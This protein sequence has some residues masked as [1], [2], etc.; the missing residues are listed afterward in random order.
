MLSLV[1]LCLRELKNNFVTHSEI[2]M[3][4][5]QL[6]FPLNCRFFTLVW[7]PSKKLIENISIE[8]IACIIDNSPKSMIC[9]HISFN[10]LIKICEII[11]DKSLSTM[12]IGMDHY[13]FM[14]VCQMF[15]IIQN[16]LS[17]NFNYYLE[18]CCIWG[19]HRNFKFELYELL[20]QHERDKRINELH[21]NDRINYFSLMNI[22]DQTLLFMH[23]SKK[24][25][26][27]AVESIVS[28][29]CKSRDYTVAIHDHIYGTIKSTILQLPWVK[30]AHL[31]NKLYL[32]QVT[33]L[34]KS[35][36]IKRLKYIYMQ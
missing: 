13:K 32:D 24:Q 7:P 26:I 36:Q 34:C 19:A 23:L 16:K 33:D 18:K 31:F 30:L 29:I 25:K 8:T 10:K 27:I 11:S 17:R 1:E 15:H 35:I 20:S 6:P 21:I 5:S 4:T 3:I 9:E 14:K 12:I 2:A 28:H 22:V